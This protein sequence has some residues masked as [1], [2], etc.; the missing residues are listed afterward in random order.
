M[1]DVTDINA[2]EKWFDQQ[3]REV[4]IIIA[5]RCALRVFPRMNALLAHKEKLGR[6]PSTIILPSLWAISTVLSA[7]RWPDKAV[8]LRPYAAAAYD[9]AA[10]A[11]RAAAYTAAA[12]AAAYTA[13]AAAAA[14]DAADAAAARSAA[15]TAASAAR[16]DALR[17]DM[18]FIE[19]GGTAQAL[20]Q[21]PLWNQANDDFDVA[22]YG[23]KLNMPNELF[24]DWQN[25]KSYLIGLNENWEV[26]SDWYEDRLRGGVP[27]IQTLEISDPEN[28]D[29]GRATFPDVWYKDPA[30]L[31]AALKEKI[32]DYWAEQDQLLAQDT[33][34]EI[35]DRNENGQIDIK[36]QQM[37][38][39]LY[40]SSAQQEWYNSLR[41]AV[42]E[43][44]AAGQQLGSVK[45]PLEKVQ[46]ALPEDMGQAR[47][48]K[49]WPRMNKIRRLLK[50]HEKATAS[51]EF[52]L[53]KIDED[54][55]IDLEGV[56]G[57]YNNLRIGDPH[58]IA[59][60]DNALSPQDTDELKSTADT[61][62]PIIIEAIEENIVTEK[63]AEVLSET[64]EN[65]SEIDVQNSVMG[66]AQLT[67]DGKTQKNFI[68]SL[69]KN[70]RDAGAFIAVGRGAIDLV[71]FIAKHKETI[72][73]TFKELAEFLRDLFL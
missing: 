55:A 35:F 67:Q 59:A 32:D 5:A 45:K 68:R 49:L 25:L 40:I 71:K 30:K 13:A 61:I 60:D 7:V 11:A 18:S 15:Y 9:A 14:Y 24:S 56:V 8:V 27:L 43:A 44:L 65:F 63:A 53:D 36:T 42:E 52:S 21:Q 50:K 23:Y 62:N 72:I 57:T 69:V 12:R 26:W 28:G 31:N 51:E 73:S 17:A 54:V 34:A 3:E 47:V 1:V 22:R 64:Q 39:G 58:L 4:S 70:A 6:P 2:L 48:A 19:D 46:Q 33:T 37:G 66:R 16:A 38:E 20:S 41:E 29:Y 10:A